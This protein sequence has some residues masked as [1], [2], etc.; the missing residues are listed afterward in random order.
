MMSNFVLMKTSI[1][2]LLLLVLFSCA[3]NASQSNKTIT[4]AKICQQVKANT[5]ID[6]GVKGMVCQMGCG[7]S[8]RKALK[9][10]CA[11][12]RVEVNYLDSL[13]EQTIKV[14]YDR[15]KIAPKQMLHILSKINDQQFSVRTIGEAQALR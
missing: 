12:E 6:F 1:L 10:T 9:E 5:A 2:S 3:Q 14:H 13:E 15:Q 4:P 11:V 7:G 8:I